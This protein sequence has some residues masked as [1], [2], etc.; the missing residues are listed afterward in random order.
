MQPSTKCKLVS[1]EDFCDSLDGVLKL[2]S[3]I[4]ETLLHLTIAV[5]AI[6]IFVPILQLVRSV[7]STI[8]RGE[9]YI[10]DKSGNIRV[11][12][13]ASILSADPEELKKFHQDMLRDGRQTAA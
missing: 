3:D 4:I 7:V 6:S 12:T 5:S 10:E 8:K 11:F 2:G 13:P 9:V 1:D